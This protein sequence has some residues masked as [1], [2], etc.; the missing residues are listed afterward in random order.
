ML[1][2]DEPTSHLDLKNK[3]R[4]VDG[5]RRAGHL[6]RDDPLHHPRAGPRG[7]AGHD[8]VLLHGG[9]V[10]RAGPVAEALTG[11]DLSATY[12]VQR[13]R[14]RSGRAPGDLLAVTRK[15]E[16]G[17]AWEGED[18]ALDDCRPEASL[19]GGVALGETREGSATRRELLRSDVTAT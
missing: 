5:D 10:L 13:A 16:A 17:A 6:G 12:G 8:L 19:D 1:L 7:G 4:M 9:S 14:R 11:E 2:L 15:E 18:D 3:R